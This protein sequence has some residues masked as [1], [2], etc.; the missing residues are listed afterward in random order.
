VES[1]ET[2]NWDDNE[3]GEVSLMLCGIFEMLER[4][5]TFCGEV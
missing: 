3:V 5:E 4:F 1:R 2:F